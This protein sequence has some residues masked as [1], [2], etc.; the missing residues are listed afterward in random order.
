MKITEI[1]LVTENWKGTEKNCL[2]TVEDYLKYVDLDQFDSR[3][4]VADA[5]LELGR[6]LENENEWSEYYFAS[7]KSVNARFCMDVEQLKRF[8]EGFYNSTDQKDLF[9]KGMCSGE[10]LDKLSKLCMDTKGNVNILNFSYTQIYSDFEQGARFNNFNG[11]D[12]RVMEKLSR[13]NLLLRDEESGN[14]VVALGVLMFVR[15]PRGTEAKEGN[16]QVGI[17]WEHGVYL[18]NTPSDIDFRHIRQEYG[19]EKTVEDIYDYREMLQDRFCR[20]SNISED[21]RLSET[22]REAVMYARYDEFGTNDRSEFQ[23]CLNAGRYDSGFEKM[24]QEETERT[25]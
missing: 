11:R 24:K 7:N 23:K 12:Y 3:K 21:K 18:G 6:T 25:R 15:Y 9:D 16:C 19:T 14:F 4:D 5:M 22:V 1:V 8:L 20:Y 2:M 17:E 10:C 13:K